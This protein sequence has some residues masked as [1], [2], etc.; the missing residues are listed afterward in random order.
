MKS[1]IF[2]LLSIPLF[3]IGGCALFFA[4]LWF[5]SEASKLFQTL[6]IVGSVGSC[7]G[8]VSF[9]FFLLF[10]AIEES[11]NDDETIEGIEEKLLE[12]TNLQIKLRHT[13]LS[14]IERMSALFHEP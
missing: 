1:F 5:V 10:K 4:D 2:L 6:Q 9:I 14:F 12:Q 7:L 3:T 11:K 8:V 13:Q